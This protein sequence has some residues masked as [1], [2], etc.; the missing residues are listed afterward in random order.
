VV[1]AVCALAVGLGVAPA[2]AAS[3]PRCIGLNYTIRASNYNT[4]TYHFVPIMTGPRLVSPVSTVASYEVNNL[5]GSL[6]TT[7]NRGLGVDVIIWGGWR[8]T[9]LRVSVQDARINFSNR[10]YVC[11]NIFYRR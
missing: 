7:Y 1:L 9:W 6:D 10:Y 11:P 4:Y 5:A 3:L 8:I 2:E